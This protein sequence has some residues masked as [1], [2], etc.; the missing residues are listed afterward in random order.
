MIVWNQKSRRHHPQMAGIVTPN[1]L[2]LWSS[3][4]IATAATL[5]YE[6]EDVR[7]EEDR[8]RYPRLLKDDE[9]LLVLLMS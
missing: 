5:G 1:S 3:G 8:G 6:W 9:E 2:Y 4:T 7:F